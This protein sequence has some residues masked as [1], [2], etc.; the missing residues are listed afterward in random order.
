M[1]ATLQN[2]STAQPA[3]TVIHWML[4]AALSIFI[5]LGAI[6][7]LIALDRF[8][9]GLHFDEAVYGLLARDILHGA[10]PVF[11][12]AWTGREPL[13]M[14]LMALVQAVVGVNT[15]AIRMTSALIGLATLPLTYLLGRELFNRRVALL[16]A[17]LLTTNYW[18]LTVSRN[19]Y[20]NILIPPLE[21][22]SFYFL[23]RAYGRPSAYP[24]ASAAAGGLL[25][26]LVLY[27]YLAARFY[28][29]T[30]LVIAAY[31]LLVDR[32]RFTRQ[33]PALAVVATI[34]MIAVVT[35]LAGHF[36]RN[37]HDF[38]E[39]AG[40][41]LIFTQTSSASEGLRLFLTNVWQTALAFFVRGD[42][43]WHYNL[44]GKPTFDP[45]IAVFFVAGILIALRHW[46]ELPYAAVL[47]WTAVMCLPGILTADLQPAGQRMFGMFP[48]L[49]MLPA[50]GLDAAWHWIRDQQPRLVPLAMA[51]LVLLFAWEGFSTTRTYFCDWVRRYETYEI[52]NG[53]YAQMAGV[54]RQE[55]AAGHTVVFVSEHYKHPTLAYLAPETMGDAVWTLGERGLVFPARG[56]DEIVYLVP[57]EPFPPE[58]RVDRT[59]RERAHTV[60]TV[61]DFAGRPAF[62]VYRV[63][64]EP[65]SVTAARLLAL[66]KSS[67]RP[68]ARRASA[69]EGPTFNGE[70]RFIDAE[71][72]ASS[73]RDA[74]ISVTVRWQV[75]KPV[76]QARTF[77]LHLVDDRGLRWAQTDEMSYL[78]EQWHPDD[79][80][81]Q[82]LTLPLDLT[83]PAGTYTLQLALTDEA[84][85]PL[86]V[87]GGVPIGVWLKLG[88]VTL[89]E[90]GG[91]IEP[92]GRG[93][94]MGSS[95]QVMDHG[96]AAG[97]VAPGA[98]LILSVVWQ[99]TGALTREEAVRIELV[100]R[101]EQPWLSVE[102]PIAGQYP[103][104]M[105]RLGE[106]VRAQ[107]GVTVPADAPSGPS[108]VLLR[109]GDA[110]VILGEIDIQAE[111]RLFAPP[112][113]DTPLRARFGES[114]QLLGY[115]LPRIT[116]APGDT[117][118]LT[119]YWQ[120]LRA[121]E[122]DYKV[123]T[124]LLDPAGQLR[125]QQDSVPVGGA[126]PTTGWIKDEII[127][128]QYEIP[129]SPDA[130]AGTYQIEI[131][132][133]EATTIMRLPAFD[134]GGNPLPDNRVLLPHK[135]RVER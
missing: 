125:G 31:A 37:P 23:W 69:L 40:Q 51:G 133:Y 26:G 34:A 75:L 57:R 81:E 127:I 126:R 1:D 92:I 38:V 93:V 55:M 104:S 29:I 99:K 12:S 103:P 62:T 90:A 67:A 119:L 46:R 48:A 64:G 82:W 134:A 71:W 117:V 41:V 95:L 10:R 135:W 17:G 84:A 36:I 101:A 50:L 3:R 87:L 6:I 78:S 25:T 116:F 114:I 5:L 74:M 124:H 45:L 21:A 33:S 32:R 129:L 98:R 42:P 105:W 68:R 24:L 43:R 109:L 132:L 123:F 122:G 96:P 88:D 30:L 66:S 35:P 112:E 91:R 70:A 113:I 11:F 4:T 15:L 49:A 76:S 61:N 39:R 111:G 13:Y 108:R 131:G 97:S 118:P 107:Y 9:P 8:P 44:P 27:T 18:H 28:P 47:I 106:V 63:W 110:T 22:L 77:A 56:A 102:Q 58:S 73:A 53:D 7:R 100:N 128:D 59:L 14:Y 72:P 2:R 130:P 52:F 19:G 121:I 80:V 20:P 86:P 54:A 60:E 94:P 120:A 89:T 16:A 83:T 115:D 65:V 85:H 79:L